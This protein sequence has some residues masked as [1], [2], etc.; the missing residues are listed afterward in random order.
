MMQSMWMTAAGAHTMPGMMSDGPPR[1]DRDRDRK[2]KRERENFEDPP[3]P[4]MDADEDVIEIPRAILG[5]VI[6]KGGEALREI[7]QR[8]GARVDIRDEAPDCPYVQVM[9][10]GNTENVPMAKQLVQDLLKMGREAKKGEMYV[11]VPRNR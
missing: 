5:K 6:G 4:R 3:M 9:L 8:S 10:K 11:E 7:R 2:R 1:G